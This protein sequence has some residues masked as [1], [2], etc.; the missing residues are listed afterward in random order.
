MVSD[1]KKETIAPISSGDQLLSSLQAKSLKPNNASPPPPQKQRFGYDLEGFSPSGE[2]LQGILSQSGLLQNTRSDSGMQFTANLADSLNVSFAHN[3]AGPVLNEDSLNS[4]LHTGLR[5]QECDNL[6]LPHA[7]DTRVLREVQD[8]SLEDNFLPNSPPHCDESGTGSQWLKLPLSLATN[9]DIA[10]STRNHDV[11]EGPSSIVCVD[12]FSDE[13]PP[14]QLSFEDFEELFEPNY[15]NVGIV[16]LHTDPR[17][18]EAVLRSH[19]AP[20]RRHIKADSNIKG[21]PPF[22]DL[23]AQHSSWGVAQLAVAKPYIPRSAKVDHLIQELFG[24]DAN[25]GYS[26]PGEVISLFRSKIFSLTYR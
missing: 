25:M 15:A 13:D 18:R 19:L 6:A 26:Y 12:E 24:K 16:P 20:L 10:V 8:S 22:D 9:Y 11:E 5:N 1:P 21:E 23:P 7:I 17:V 2:H 14:Q 4:R 3:T